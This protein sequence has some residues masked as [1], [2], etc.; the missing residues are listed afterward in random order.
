MFYI[1]V[2]KKNSKVQKYT[3]F[4]SLLLN[5]PVEIVETKLLYISECIYNKRC[6]IVSFKNRIFEIYKKE[7]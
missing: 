3:T 2:N 4:E 6:A 5:L 7:V 1:Q